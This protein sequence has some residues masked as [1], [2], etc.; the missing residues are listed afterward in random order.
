MGPRIRSERD[1]KVKTNN[2]VKHVTECHK[3]VHLAK[4]ESFH[5]A[6]MQMETKGGKKRFVNTKKMLKTCTYIQLNY[7]VVV[8]QLGLLSSAFSSDSWP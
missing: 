8:C 5:L 6:K 1:H 2:N 7:F 3:A 4:I